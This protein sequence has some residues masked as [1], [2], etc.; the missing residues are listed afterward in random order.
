MTHFSLMC[1]GPLCQPVRKQTSNNRRRQKSNYFCCPWESRNVIYVAVGW[2]F[3]VAW[4]FSFGSVISFFPTAVWLLL[5]NF[6]MA[7]PS[8]ERIEKIVEN[9]PTSQ[10]ELESEPELFDT[11][12]LVFTSSSSLLKSFVTSLNNSLPIP[13]SSPLLCRWGG[14]ISEHDQECPS[15]S[16]CRGHYGMYHGV[17]AGCV[18]VQTPDSQALTSAHVTTGCARYVW[19]TAGFSITYT[20]LYKVYSSVQLKYNK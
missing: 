5:N 3:S 9:A 10:H 2:I 11:S 16:S 12:L 7:F 14:G 20:H 8:D 15:R 6:S 18:C 19:L 4:L 17:G 1:C 13:V